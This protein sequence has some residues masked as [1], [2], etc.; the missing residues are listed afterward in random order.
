MF[1]F[2]DSIF[3]QRAPQDVFD[4]ISDP[5][6]SVQWQSSLESGEWTSEAPFGAGSTWKVKM[7]FKGRTLEA[8]LEVTGPVEVVL[9]HQM[10]TDI[11]FVAFLSVMR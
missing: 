6:K 1:E 4:V 2:E 10:T 7:K 11:L 3:I 8:D 5:A 9:D